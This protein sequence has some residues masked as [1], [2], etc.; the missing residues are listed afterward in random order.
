MVLILCSTKTVVK[1]TTGVQ[2]IFEREGE[3]IC[4]FKL[5]IWK[6]H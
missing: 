1:E 3:V 2:A 6:Y 5:L 4:K